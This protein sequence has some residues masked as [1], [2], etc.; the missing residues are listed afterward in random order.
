MPVDVS[1]KAGT[2]RDKAETNRDK[3]G[4]AGNIPF[5]PCISLLVPAYPCLSL[6]FP[7]SPCLFLSI[8]VCSSPPMSVPVC[9]CLF[10]PVLV[11]SC[12]SLCVL[13]CLCLSLYVSAF[14]RPAFLPSADEYHSL[15]Q[16]GHSY[17]DLLCKSHC[18]NACTSYL[19]FFVLLYFWSCLLKNSFIQSEPPHLVSF[20]MCFFSIHECNKWLSFSIPLMNIYGWWFL[21]FTQNFLQHILDAKWMTLW[22]LNIFPSRWLKWHHRINFFSLLFAHDKSNS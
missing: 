14:A 3:Q 9:P 18:S 1:D 6:L 15:P 4:Q 11:S 2:S 5:C 21:W 8:P 22:A 12:L 17:I 19:N 7:V 16:Y 13:V 10:L 20:K